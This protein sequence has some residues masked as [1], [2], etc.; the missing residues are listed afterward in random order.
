VD[1]S[2]QINKLFGFD[3]TSKAK[4]KAY[5]QRKAE[6]KGCFSCQYTG[7][8]TNSDSTTS[9]C[10]C[11]KEKWLLSIFKKS[12]VPNKYIGKTLDDWETRHN[13]SDMDTNSQNR[14][15][16]EIIRVLKFYEKNI[17]NICRNLCPKIK[18]NTNQRD[19]LHSLQ[20]VGNTGSG[21]TFIASVMVQHAIRKQLTAKYY[22]WSELLE[23]LIDYNRKDEV[24][25]LVEE[26]K[27]LDFIAIDGVQSFNINQPHVAIQL[28]R[29]GKARSNSGKPTFIMV[30]GDITKI[31]GG[32]G[33]TSLIKSCLT[34]QLPHAIK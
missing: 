18:H 29:I 11:A 1:S 21:K 13:N 9:M 31:E 33:W 20:F 4:E 2:D 7:Y 17:S 30:F 19:S 16:Q 5:R 3:F 15:S 12:N 22:D 25:E 10:S 14:S 23:T 28:D 24:T 26:F 6:G 34:I 27:E 8:I 32:S